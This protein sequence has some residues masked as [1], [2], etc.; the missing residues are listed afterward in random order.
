MRAAQDADSWLLT[1]Y[2]LVLNVLWVGIDLDGEC[3]GKLSGRVAGLL[4]GQVSQGGLEGVALFA[5]PAAPLLLAWPW[6][7][8]RAVAAGGRI[9]CRL[10]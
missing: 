1:G 5:V 8:S 2:F 6:C 10:G 4:D 9:F 3:C 7:S